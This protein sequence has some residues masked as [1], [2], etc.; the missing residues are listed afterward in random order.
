MNHNQASLLES[1]E[2]AKVLESDLEGGLTVS[3]AHTR[4]KHYGA[5][6]LNEIAESDG[7]LKRYLW[8]NLAKFL[9]QFLNP[10]IQL[11]LL[12]VIVSVAIGEHENSASIME[13]ILIV[14]SISYF[15][16]RR[17]D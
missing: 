7:T 4:L 2:V 15:Q 10:L 17:A 3:E 8:D 9:S 5:N 1:E 11:L 6:R 16:E 14:C 13:A 12:C